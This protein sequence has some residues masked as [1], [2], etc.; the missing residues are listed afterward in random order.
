MPEFYVQRPGAG[1]ILPP[2]SEGVS[3]TGEA[4]G[5][6]NGPAFAGQGLHLALGKRLRH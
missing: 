6:H 1:L 4:N 5:H 2:V 3:L